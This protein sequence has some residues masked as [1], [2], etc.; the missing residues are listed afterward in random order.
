MPFT[1][2]EQINFATGASHQAGTFT[3]ITAYK[4]QDNVPDYFKVFTKDGKILTYGGSSDARVQP[5]LLTAGSDMAEP[6]P[7]R[8]PGAPRATTAWA[9]D[10]I[11][12]RN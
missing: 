6:S 1:I 5:Y 10:R 2:T 12:D 7:V 11:E 8:A 3:R 4:T 9:L